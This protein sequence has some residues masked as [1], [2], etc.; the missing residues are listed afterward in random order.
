MGT[1]QSAYKQSGSSI[2]ILVVEDHDQFRQFV[3]STLKKG[4]ELD[5]V[6]EV[7]DG[8][9]AVHKAE[10]LQPDLILLDIGLPSLNGI[11]AAR[12]ICNL[13][14]TSKIVFL[15]QESSADV[16]QRAFSV[17][18][19]GYV[20]KPQ[21]GSELLPAVGA[22]ILGIRFVSFGLV[23]Q[24]H[25]DPVKDEVRGRRRPRNVLPLLPEAVD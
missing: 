1:D 3:C 25:A 7:S 5:V 15:S 4:A 10:E 8:L 13:V 24:A 11:E 23:G 16:V 17:G 19:L 21:A 22:A 9:E 20:V 12:R 2:R 18:A 14:P 6:G